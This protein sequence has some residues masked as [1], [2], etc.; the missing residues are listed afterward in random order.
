[1]SA[2]LNSFAFVSILSALVSLTASIATW[3]R[4]APG[5]SA[6]SLLLAAMAIWAAGYATRWM[7]ISVEAKLFWF[8]VMF[9]GVASVPTLF[10][11]FTLGLIH[12]EAW[13]TPRRLALLSIQPVTSLLLHWTNEYHHFVYLSISMNDSVMIEL[14]RGPWYFVN[15]V[16]SYAVIAIGFLL[17]SQGAQRLGPLYRSQY[18][19]I[20]VASLL[21][22]AASVFSEL[23]FV[24][25]NNLDLTPLTFGLAGI[26][27]AF[28]I[29]QTH[30][31][32]LIP[33]ARS[34]LIENMYDG[35]MVLDAQNRVVDINPAMEHLL[36][37]S[38][39]FYLGK[40]AADVFDGWMQKANVL[41]DATETRAELKVPQEPPRYLDLRVTPLYDRDHLLNGRLM[42]FRDVTERKQDEKRLRYA[43][44]RLQTQLIEIG[45]LQSKLREQA[46]R[47]PLTNLFNRRYLEE[48]LD[49]ELARAGRESYPVC[50]IMVDLDYFKK[51]NDTYGHDAG[52]QV[53][54]ALANT[55]A[56]QSRRGDFACRYGGEEFVIVM[57]NITKRTAYERAK[58]LRRCLNALQ[59]PYECH[60]LTTTISMGIACYPT[61]GDTRQAL[62]R[63]A[64]QAMYAAKR[65][66]RDHILTYDQ[67]LISGEAQK[68]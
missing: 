41:G 16:Y 42:V 26:I 57:P 54:R 59:I 1:M 10:L 8:K 21:P 50:I 43:N 28:S 61:N 11:V 46:I 47:D 6:L 20:V 33:V 52:D 37:K 24:T 17:M 25:S 31:M 40:N 55:L 68:D 63:A 34:H 51:I 15:V 53:L 62:L 2:Q 64:D 35:V 67:F 19:L 32:D 58:K 65:A 14:T 66:G 18:R 29:L 30:F 13:L 36:E 12:N 23:T 56:E 39:S 60:R 49:R 44:E 22:W 45:L 5:S 9:I 38:P 3:R 7:H 48:T 4:E 27:Y